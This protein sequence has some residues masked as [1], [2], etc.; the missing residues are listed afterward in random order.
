MPLHCWRFTHQTRANRKL[1]LAWLNNEMI[2]AMRPTD[3]MTIVMVLQLPPHCLADRFWL[4]E[5][6]SCSIYETRD[7]GGRAS[8]CALWC[9]SMSQCHDQCFG[10][11]L[12]NKTTCVLCVQYPDQTP[13][14]LPITGTG[15]KRNSAEPQN[16]FEG[17]V[18]KLICSSCYC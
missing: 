14:G 8:E 11:M 5:F 7:V 3:L 16:L 2:I 1:E 15:Y 6:L 9:Q 4:V 12:I 10:F 17:I 13:V 18:I